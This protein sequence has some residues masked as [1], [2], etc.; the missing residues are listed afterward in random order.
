[1]ASK[2]DV[3]AAEK[4]VLRCAN[5]LSAALQTLSK[6]ASEIAGEDLEAMLCN[7]EEIEF[8]VNGRDSM[9]TYGYVEDI[10]NML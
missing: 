3:I 7:G 10:L 1:M 2:K 9:E 6:I 8:R 4:K 5:E